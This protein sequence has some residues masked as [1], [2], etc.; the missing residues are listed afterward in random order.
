MN[1]QTENNSTEAR[2]PK[3]RTPLFIGIVVALLGVIIFFYYVNTNLKEEK[4]AQALELN[5]TLLQL[6]SISSELDNKILTIQQLGGEVDTLVKIRE[7]LQSERK[8]LL[9]EIDNRKNMISELR[10]RV[11]GYQQLLLAKDEEIEQLTLINEQLMSENTELKNETQE[12]S[13]SIQE[14]NQAKEELAEKVA[15]AARLKVEGMR[16]YAVNENGREREGEFRNRHIDQ[17][18]INFTVG[19]NEVAPIEGKEL[20]IRVVAPDGQV[21]FDV[22][23]GSGSFMYEGREMFYTAKQEILYDKNSQEVTVFYDKGSEYAEGKH[24][25]EVYTDQYLMGKGTFIVK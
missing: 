17:I 7:K 5:N 22:T 20:L 1:E 21:L 14:I 18:K 23:R 24:L 4:A 3:D 25:V 15:F 10:A 9:T 16:I 19:A 11:G 8:L 13:A 6:D 12:L 2:K